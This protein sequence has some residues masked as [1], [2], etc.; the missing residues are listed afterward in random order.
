[1]RKGPTEQAAASSDRACWAVPL[2]RLLLQIPGLLRSETHTRN[3]PGGDF[4]CF[5]ATA[6]ATATAIAVSGVTATICD[7]GSTKTNA[8]DAQPAW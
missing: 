1:V 4:R 8:G 5:T 6:T 3:D 2:E 7:V